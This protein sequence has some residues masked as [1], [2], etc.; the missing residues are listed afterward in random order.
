MPLASQLRRVDWRVL[1]G[2]DAPP[3]RAVVTP[4]L[5]ATLD[6]AIASLEDAPSFEAADSVIRHA[7]EFSRH[8]IRVERVGV[9]VLDEAAPVMRGTWGTSASGE[10]SD[11]HHLVYDLGDTDRQVF[12][13]AAE[14]V[15]WLVFD[16]CPIV[17][18]A[19]GGTRVLGRGWLA[20]TAIVGPR[21][22]FGILFNDGA[23][24]GAPFDEAKQA[25]VTLLCSLLGR[26]L[27]QCRS[28][29]TGAATARPRPRHPLV[30]RAIKRLG[31]DPALAVTALAE[32]LKVSPGRLAR[33]FKQEMGVSIVDHRNELRLA[34][35]LSRVAPK[36]TNLLEAALAAG[37]G[38]YA[39]F[40]R[41]FRDRFGDSPRSYLAHQ[42]PPRP[43][44]GKK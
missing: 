28:L 39:Q 42:D 20:C 27:D 40:H 16:D 4:L 34:R 24:T 30:T 18:H 1:I 6:G 43:P 10:T 15:P 7:V 22:P 33:V 2:Q 9:F 35:F 8:V 14:G 12:A 11:E 26:A 44:G 38:S 5:S 41:V 21:G 37:F 32:Q 3:P 31:A 25:L 36:G 19:P 23:L 29:L 17:D 13:K